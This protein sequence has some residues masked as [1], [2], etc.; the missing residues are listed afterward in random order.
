MPTLPTSLLWRRTDTD[1][2]DHVL[3]DDSAGLR[4]RG[5]AVAAAPLPHTCRYEL[6]TDPEW[7]VTRLEVTAEGGGWSRTVELERAADRWRVTTAERGD[8]NR[9][10]AAAG[11]PRTDLPG[12]EDPD[13]LAEAVDVDLAA[14]PLFNTL[15]VRRLGL[16]DAPANTDHH[17]MVAWVK[18]P[19]LEV[20]PSEQVYSTLDG[21]RVRYRSG[22]FAVDLDLDEDGYVRTY[23]GLAERTA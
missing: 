20:L 17:L 1:G 11:R 14:A 22:T 2:Y 12:M 19:S 23:P 15:P 8:L 7:A 5:T 9:A 18:L 16:R 13:R 4:A 21:P 3:L 6:T 10:L